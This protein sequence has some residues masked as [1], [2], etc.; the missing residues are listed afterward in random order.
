MALLLSLLTFLIVVAIIA[1]VWMFV[2]T[3][4]NQ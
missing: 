3:D 4:A 2:G 1:L